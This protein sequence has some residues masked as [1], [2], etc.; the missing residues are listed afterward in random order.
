MWVAHSTLDAQSAATRLPCSFG[1]GAARPN[2]TYQIY[3]HS[4]H[5]TN[6]L[7]VWW[8]PLEQ[9]PYAPHLDSELPADARMAYRTR[10]AGNPIWV[11]AVIVQR[12]NLRT[13]HARNAYVKWADNPRDRRAVRCRTGFRRLVCWIRARAQ[14]EVNARSVVL[15]YLW[16]VLF[17][18]W[19]QMKLLIT[20]LIQSP[21]KKHHFGVMLLKH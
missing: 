6:R 14:F 19:W 11:N 15:V 13:Q 10:V 9:N 17:F 4:S 1:C 18:T 12:T 3:M 8:S 20:G 16:Y 5:H 2:G 21:G 7:R